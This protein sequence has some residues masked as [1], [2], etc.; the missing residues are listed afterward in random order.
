MRSFKIVGV[1][2]IFKEFGDTL[3]VFQSVMLWA[4]ATLL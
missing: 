2:V 1:S 3:E 4:L